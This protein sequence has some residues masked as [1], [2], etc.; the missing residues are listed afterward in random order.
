[1]LRLRGIEMSMVG[2]RKL[3]RYPSGLWEDAVRVKNRIP[4]QRIDDDDREK[5]FKYVWS[6]S[7]E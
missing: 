7:W 3:T 1:M 4:M 6:L 5:I 2:P